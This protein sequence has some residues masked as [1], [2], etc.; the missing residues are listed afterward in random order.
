MVSEWGA[1]RDVLGDL[2]KLVELVARGKRFGIRLDD[3]TD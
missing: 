1:R 2:F 3:T